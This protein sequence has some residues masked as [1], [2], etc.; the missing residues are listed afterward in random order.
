[1]FESESVKSDDI[2]LYEWQYLVRHQ[3]INCFT[4]GEKVFVTI[5]PDLPMFVKGFNGEYVIVEWLSKDKTLIVDEWYPQCI[6][7][8]KYAALMV[9]KEKFNVCLN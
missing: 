9:Y 1:M 5:K 2:V 4:V 6:L 7:Q 3:N 8:Y